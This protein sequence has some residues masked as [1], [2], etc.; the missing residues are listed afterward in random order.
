MLED[1][2]QESIRHNPTEALGKALWLLRRDSLLGLRAGWSQEPRE[3]AGARAQAEEVE[4]QTS[5]V[6]GGEQSCLEGAL[7]RAPTIWRVRGEDE[8]EG[9][10]D[11]AVSGR[12]WWDVVPK[13]ETREENPIRGQTLIFMWASLGLRGH[14]EIQG[15]RP[16]GSWTL[17]AG[18]WTDVGIWTQGA[19]WPKAQ[20]EPLGCDATCQAEAEPRPQ[21]RRHSL[22]K[23]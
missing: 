16:V 9:D 23:C 2:K 11:S 21:A 12:Y 6:A 1:L 15:G 14:G 19:F 17:M 10:Q 13:V 22:P 20:L 4:A 18:A 7:P 8:E 5:A 3:A